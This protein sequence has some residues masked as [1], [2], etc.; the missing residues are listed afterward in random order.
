MRTQLDPAYIARVDTE[1]M[2]NRLRLDDEGMK[3][4]IKLHMAGVGRA[5]REGEYP[6]PLYLRQAVRLT[7]AGL[8]L[9]A[10]K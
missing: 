1:A 3:L 10:R 7:Q 5:P 8:K 4:A 6:A 2:L 9:E